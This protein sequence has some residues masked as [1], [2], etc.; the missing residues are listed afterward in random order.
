MMGSPSVNKLERRW[1]RR[2]ELNNG[3]C[4]ETPLACDQA[5][6]STGTMQVIQKNR[7]HGAAIKVRFVDLERTTGP[8]LAKFCFSPMPLRCICLFGSKRQR[9]S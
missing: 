5:W 2:D 3:G 4:G 6:L 8:S 1:V 9:Q 7:Q